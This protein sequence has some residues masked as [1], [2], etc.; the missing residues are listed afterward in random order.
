MS[1]YLTFSPLPFRAVIFCGTIRYAVSRTF[2][3]GSIVLCAARTFLK[4]RLEDASA[5]NRFACAIQK[6]KFFS[7]KEAFRKYFDAIHNFAGKIRKMKIQTKKYQLDTQL[8]LRIS[9]L[10]VNRKWWWAWLVPAA[11]FIVFALADM[12]WWGLGVAVT[13]IILY[14]LFWAVQ[15]IGVT[16]HANSKL[17]FDKYFYIIDAKQILM[18][19][20]PEKGMPIAWDMIK[21]AKKENDAYLLEIS[22][23]QFLHMPFSIFKTEQDLRVMDMFLV[24]KNLLPAKE[25]ESAEKKEKK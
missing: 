1:S 15:F 10:N 9:L 5:M 25:K 20:T 14:W 11:V 4:R 18:M 16:Q 3:L 22:I 13:L 6:Y 8:Y 17:F 21:S 24:R 7:K 19:Q 2:P 23:A 12:I